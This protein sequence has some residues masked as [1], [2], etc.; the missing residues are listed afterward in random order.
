VDGQAD[1]NSTPGLVDLAADPSV[2]LFSFL[3]FSFFFSEVLGFELRAYT[4]SHSIS[5][6]FVMDFFQDG[7]L[8]TTCQGWRPTLIFLI[9]AS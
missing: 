9:S 2:R 4:L 6:I 8:R 5:P 3:F 1:W 7:V